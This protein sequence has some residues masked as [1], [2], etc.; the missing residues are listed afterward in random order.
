MLQ[1][2]WGVVLQGV[3]RSAGGKKTSRD[4][5]LRHV[6]LGGRVR[7]ICWP[8]G[9]ALC[10]ALDDPH[11]RAEEIRP[12]GGG[13]G[14]INRPRPRPDPAYSPLKRPNI[15]PERPGRPELRPHVH[16][17]AAAGAD[18]T[19]LRMPHNARSLTEWH[20]HPLPH[21]TAVSVAPRGV[22]GI[23]GVGCN[24][25]VEVRGGLGIRSH[26]QAGGAAIAGLLGP[27]EPPPDV[28]PEPSRATLRPVPCPSPLPPLSPCVV[29][30]TWSGSRRSG[31]RASEQVRP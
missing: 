3:T 13:S 31:S 19:V 30:L 14:P 29:S 4:M 25:V 5:S 2:F 22:Q 17:D 21:K 12:G 16:D 9:C 7:K 11:A 28:P 18:T 6:F 26:A 15:P 10:A 23:L 24:W 1:P 27:P 8:V 20:S